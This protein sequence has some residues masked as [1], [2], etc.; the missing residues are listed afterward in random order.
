MPALT[1]AALKAL[2][3]SEIDPVALRARQEA[4]VAAHGVHEQ[5]KGDRPLVDGGRSVVVDVYDGPRGKGWITR[6]F[7][8]V[9]G[10]LYCKSVDYG[11]ENNS[12]DWRVQ[13]E[14]NP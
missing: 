2:A 7:I 1:L 11:P 14:R 10:L 4:H 3:D 9:G 8:R 13:T 12:H 5:I 6:C